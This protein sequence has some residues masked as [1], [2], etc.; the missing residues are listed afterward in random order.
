VRQAEYLA[1]LPDQ[2]MLELRQKLK[3][4]LD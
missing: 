3:T 1:A 4:L 2:V